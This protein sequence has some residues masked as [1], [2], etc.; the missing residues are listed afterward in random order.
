MQYQ[1]YKETDCRSSAIVDV[2]KRLSM[3]DKIDTFG[4]AL[5]NSS[6]RLAVRKCMC[7]LADLGV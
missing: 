3:S 2:V 7:L 4:Y 6:L 1:T 5:L